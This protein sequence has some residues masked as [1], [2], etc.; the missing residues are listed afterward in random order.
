[1][2]NKRPVLAT[3]G[4]NG[5]PKPLR[6]QDRAIR[7]VSGIGLPGLLAHD[8]KTSL[9]SISMNLDF[10]MAELDASAS[11]AVLAALHD[12]RQANARAIRIVNDMADAARLAAGDHRPTFTEVDPAHVVEASVRAMQP[13]AAAR[14]VEIVATTDEATVLVA[15]E[16]FGRVVERLLERALRHSHAGSRVDI[17]Q[18]GTSITIRTAAAIGHELTTPNLALYFAEMT[19]AAMGGSAAAFASNADTLAYRVVL[20]G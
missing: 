20:P 5:R 6:P 9:A 11:D 4:S 3:V 16:L 2:T 7:G 19:M 14:G 15:A 1:M 12:C 17:E 13:E 8:V 18:R 10:A